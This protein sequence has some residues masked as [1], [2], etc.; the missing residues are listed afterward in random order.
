MGD[1]LCA[2]LAKAGLAL[3]EAL[4][5]K[6]VMELCT[7]YVRKYRTEAAPAMA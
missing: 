4:I 5:A 2:V 6:V 1:F 7:A 3:A